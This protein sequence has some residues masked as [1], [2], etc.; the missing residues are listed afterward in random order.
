M[1]SYVNRLEVAFQEIAKVKL[2][3][4][5]TFIMLRQSAL[6]HEDK[7][8]ILS[9]TGGELSKKKVDSAMW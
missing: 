1:L 7:K 8:R 9:M 3:K 6:G 4:M 5:E 2:S